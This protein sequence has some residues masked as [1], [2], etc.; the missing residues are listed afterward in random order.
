MTAGFERT[1]FDHV[2]I[3]TVNEKE[4]SVWLEED[5]VWVTNP[6]QHPLNI[7]WVRYAPG[8]RMHPTL[9]ANLH[10]AYRVDDLA[11]ALEGRE[12]LVPPFEL[13]DGFAMIAF[14]QIDGNVVELMQYTD[15]DER[16]WVT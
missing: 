13:G 5:R 8:S 11:E 9:Q 15:P 4:G 6:R 1:R 12:V 16:G 2:G 3:P 7:E 10:L 14:V